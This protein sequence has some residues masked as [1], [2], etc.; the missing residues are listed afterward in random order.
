MIQQFF[1]SKRNI[2]LL[3]RVVLNTLELQGRP[4]EEKKRYDQLLINNMKRIYKSINSDKVN[5]RNINQII[6]CSNGKSRSCNI[7][8]PTT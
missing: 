3:N 8:S 5:D 4:K 7:I 6:C 2:S 1:F